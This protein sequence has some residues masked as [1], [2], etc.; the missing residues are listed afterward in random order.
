MSRPTRG[1]TVETRRETKGKAKRGE[2]SIER[3]LR[4]RERVLCLAWMPVALRR[5]SCIGLTHT[6]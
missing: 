3:G 1:E 5:P 6:E 4:D 2:R